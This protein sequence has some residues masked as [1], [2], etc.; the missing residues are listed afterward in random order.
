VEHERR[1]LWEHFTEMVCPVL[2]SE[3]DLHQKRL[4]P[5]SRFD[6]CNGGEARQNRSQL[7]CEPIASTHEKASE[8]DHGVLTAIRSGLFVI[9][10]QIRDILL[11]LKSEGQQDW[12]LRDRQRD[13]KEIQIVRL[14]AESERILEEIRQLQNHFSL[15]R[16]PESVRWLLITSLSEVWSTLNDLMPEKLKGY[17]SMTSEESNLLENHVAKMIAVTDD[18]KKSLSDFI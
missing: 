9:E 12:L 4:R 2:G 8:M 3:Q 15:E 5:D 13:V 17:G 7:G 14:R 6:S 10:E 18:M 1:I 11:E 16:H